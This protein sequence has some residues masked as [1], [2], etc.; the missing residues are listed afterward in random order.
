MYCLLLHECFRSKDAVSAKSTRLVCQRMP[1]D[2]SLEG[3]TWSTSRV[4][5][6]SPH[7]SKEWS[8]VPM[9]LTETWKAWC[10]QPSYVGVAQMHE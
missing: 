1:G 7:E 9:S 5:V 10:C 2:L 8:G 3:Q 6:L 4:R